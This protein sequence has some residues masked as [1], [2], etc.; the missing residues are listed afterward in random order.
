MI[1]AYKEGIPVMFP[2]HDELCMSG[3]LEQATRLKKIMET[4]LDLE[5]PALTTV[6][7]GNN[8]SE[9]K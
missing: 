2:V 5:V 6:K 9:C 4:T 8:W 1:K 3:T 7:S